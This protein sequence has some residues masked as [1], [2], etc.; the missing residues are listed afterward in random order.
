[1]SKHN[2]ALYKYLPSLSSLYILYLNNHIKVFQGN[3]NGFRSFYNFKLRIMI[4][5][6]E[7]LL[8]K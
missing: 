4:W 2:F 7:S 1:M 6:G 8:I 3:A 5:H